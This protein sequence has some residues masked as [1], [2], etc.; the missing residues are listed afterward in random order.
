MGMR[1]TLF[2]RHFLKRGESRSAAVRPDSM[3]YID[4]SELVF[5]D[6][7]GAGGAG[8]AASTVRV[9]E[10]SRYEDVRAVTDCV[11]NGDILIVDYSPVAGDELQ[12]KRITA[13]LRNVVH[14]TG[15]DLAGIG[16]NLVMVTP[17]GIAIDRNK[18]R[19]SNE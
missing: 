9:A 8:A 19:V 5:E 4:L 14:D 2:K 18:I 3:E 11:Y 1:M 12:L 15:G 6:E 10:I 13:E 17:S 7:P 16:R